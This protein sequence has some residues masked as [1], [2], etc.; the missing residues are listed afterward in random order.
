MTVSD[1]GNIANAP[2]HG[3][4]RQL[5]VLSRST[6]AVTILNQTMTL[7]PSTQYD[8]RAWTRRPSTQALC[9]AYF[10]LGNYPLAFTSLDDGSTQWQQITGTF[11]PVAFTSV[12][13]QIFVKCFGTTASASNR[14]IFIDD[15]SLTPSTQLLGVA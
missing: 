15:I 6:A 5:Q 1:V 7:C 12:T 14:A 8:F 10:D 9:T 13:L 4:D 2:V 11:G 3:G